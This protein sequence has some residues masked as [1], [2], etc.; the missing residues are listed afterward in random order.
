MSEA[1]ALRSDELLNED[2]VELRLGGEADLP[3][4]IELGGKMALE[5][6][7]F[8][9][10]T[11]LPDKMMTSAQRFMQRGGTL[12]MIALDGGGVPV[13]FFTGTLE[14]YDWANDY[15]A[16]EHL[17]YL[18]PQLRGGQVHSAMF[19]VF[20]K[21]A[22]MNG[23]REIFNSMYVGAEKADGMDLMMRRMGYLR[24]G[25]NYWKGLRHG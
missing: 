22:G 4:I 17:W 12:F 25:G 5:F 16:Q 7:R 21:W 19:Q 9:G 24:I 18:I 1:A 11:Y 13:G 6:E 10:M 2:A 3:A 14:E 8:K 20:E 15:F 23:A